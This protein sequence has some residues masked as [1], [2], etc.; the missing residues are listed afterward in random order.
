MSNTETEVSNPKPSRVILNFLAPKKTLLPSI[1][2]GAGNK[3]DELAAGRDD[4]TMIYVD[5]ENHFDKNGQLKSLE[6]LPPEFRALQDA[7]KVE[8]HGHG[9]AGYGGI[10]SD[11]W[12]YNLRIDF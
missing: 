6:E 5:R 1:L 12:A 8:V 3:L 10:V 4:I 7:T 9:S 11:F 2:G